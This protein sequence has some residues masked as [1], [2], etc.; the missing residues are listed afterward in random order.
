[1]SSAWIARVALLCSSV[2]LCLYLYRRG[3][4]DRVLIDFT[5]I[6]NPQHHPGDFINLGFSLFEF[7]RAKMQDVQRQ[8]DFDL[9][10]ILL[11]DDELPALRRIMEQLLTLSVFKQII[12]WNDDPSEKLT[13]ED[14][15]DSDRSKSLLRIID[16][17]ANARHLAKY[18]A[19]SQAKTS[20]CFHIGAVTNVLGTVRSLLAS[21]RSNPTALHL[22]TNSFTLYTNV[23]TTT[24]PNSTCSSYE[25]AADINDGMLFLRTH[26]QRH[27][28]MTNG[29]LVQ[30]SGKTMLAVQLNRLMFDRG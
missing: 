30:Q 14:L 5:P 2:L 25:Q 22:I 26:A 18:H 23:L 12:V 1:M 3:Q 10:G 16:A 4:D 27:L 17:K 28:Q 7:E 9:T 24:Y 11:L 20:A 19:C 21:F 13:V 29:S 15:T 8:R 6:E